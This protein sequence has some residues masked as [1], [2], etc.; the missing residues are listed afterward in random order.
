[1]AGGLSGSTQTRGPMSAD[2]AGARAYTRA[3]METETLG[4]PRAVLQYVSAEAQQVPHEA[5]ER[6][7]RLGAYRREAVGSRD[8]GMEEGLSSASDDAAASGTP[9]PELLG[10]LAWVRAVVQHMA[11][12]ADPPVEAAPSTG[13]GPLGLRWD[14]RSRRPS[15]RVLV[16]PEQERLRIVG[17]LH[18]GAAQALSRSSRRDRGTTA[19]LTRD[20]GKRS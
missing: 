20:A 14:R 13:D 2:R 17:E 4:A 16:A 7:R 10:W 11:R 6:L 1:M 15:R 19:R 8:P 18:D 9:T 3:T 12:A 5:A